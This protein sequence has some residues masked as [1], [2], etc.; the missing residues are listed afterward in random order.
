MSDKKQVVPAADKIARPQF[1]HLPAVDVL[2]VEAPIERLEGRR[3]PTGNRVN[4]R[5]IDGLSSPRAR[6]SLADGQSFSNSASR[7]LIQL[8]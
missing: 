8:L 1:L 7:R 4:W 6:S 2:G 3:V 5:A